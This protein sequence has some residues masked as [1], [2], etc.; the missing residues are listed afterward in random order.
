MTGWKWQYAWGDFFGESDPA[1]KPVL[2]Y[3]ER[4]HLRKVRSQFW[5]TKISPQ[6][7]S[8]YGFPSLVSNAVLYGGDPKYL[9]YAYSTIIQNW[10]KSTGF[11]LLKSGIYIVY[12][13]YFYRDV[14]DLASKMLEQ[15]LKILQFFKGKLYLFC[16]IFFVEYPFRVVLFYRWAA[17][18]KLLQA[19]IEPRHC[20]SSGKFF[21][22]N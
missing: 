5:R 10:K 20:Y 13:T 17:G 21:C 3:T 1:R 4:S 14:N 6:E 16:H 18:G 19:G 15:A 7:T 12:C 2:L 22:K 9:R 8:P 11:S